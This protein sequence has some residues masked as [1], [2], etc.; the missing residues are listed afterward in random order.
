MIDSYRTILSRAKNKHDDTRKFFKTLKK[1]K[2][3]ELDLL[4]EK[5]HNLFSEKINCL[6]CANCCRG[7]GPLLK[8]RDIARLSKTLKMKKRSFTET[9]LKEDEEGDMIFKALPC[10]FID[11]NNYCIVYED[12]P[13][14]CRDYPHT[15]RR[16][17]K[18]YLKPT[19]EN[20][21]ICPIVYL[22]IEELKK[23]NL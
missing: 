9:Y 2:S 1:V 12:R 10:P 17:I 21:R 8:D 19:L 18:R 23:I 6:D 20:Y 15:D 4:F 3:G 5:Y 11:D 14:A 16:N 22:V 13:A 7:T